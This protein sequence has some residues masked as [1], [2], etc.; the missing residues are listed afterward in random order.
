MSRQ[1]RGRTFLSTAARADAWKAANA[2][3]KRALDMGGPELEALLLGGDAAATSYAQGGQP[4]PKPKKRRKTLNVDPLDPEG[5][6][7]ALQAWSAQHA[8]DG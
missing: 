6:L 7:Q 3:Y 8:P 5:Q 2:S 1:L 4:F